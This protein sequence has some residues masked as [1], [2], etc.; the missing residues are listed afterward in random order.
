VRSVQ[1]RIIIST[2]AMLAKRPES[3]SLN[4]SLQSRKKRAIKII[5]LSK[6]DSKKKEKKIF[7]PLVTKQ[8]IYLFLGRNPLLQKRKEAEVCR[9]RDNVH[10]RRL[11]T[12]GNLGSEG[13]GVDK[14]GR[15]N[16]C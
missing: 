4:W 5:P 14:K 2:F 11:G 7:F 9:P 3:V 16:G 8:K 10:F 13:S 12:Y 6:T 15:R 1:E